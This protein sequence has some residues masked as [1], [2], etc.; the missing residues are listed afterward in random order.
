MVLLLLAA[1]VK[2]FSVSRM[3]FFIMLSLTAIRV[4]T[5]A[6]VAAAGV[7]RHFTLIQGAKISPERGEMPVSPCKS[8]F[9]IIHAEYLEDN[10]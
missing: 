3:H 6:V 4:A 10:E 2:R 8:R 7:R 9:Q 5:E 1:H